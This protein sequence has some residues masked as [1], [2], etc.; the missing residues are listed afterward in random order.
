MEHLADE[1]F[2]LHEQVES[3]NSRLSRATL[4]VNQPGHGSVRAGPLRPWNHTGSLAF[5][6]FQFAA[7]GDR[8]GHRRAKS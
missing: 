4:L 8:I 7:T 1:T 3:L 2:A 5:Q 6:E